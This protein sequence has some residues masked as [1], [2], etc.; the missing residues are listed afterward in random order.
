VNESY[1]K[2]KPSSGDRPITLSDAG[3]RRLEAKY[4]ALPV[5]YVAF[6]RD[7]GASRFRGVAS[8]SV[9]G[10][11]FDVRDLYGGGRGPDSV[12]TQNFADRDEATPD[13]TIHIGSDAWGN[14]YLLRVSD[15][16]V[17]YWDRE[18]DPSERPDAVRWVAQSFDEF[19]VRIVVTNQ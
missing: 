16:A 3:L 15:G 17:L 10:V 2:M 8:I 9:D 12:V 1:A 6:L 14:A 13:G 5:E 11:E 4:G 19:L 7:V 18:I